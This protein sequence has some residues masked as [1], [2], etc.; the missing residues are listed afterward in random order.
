MAYIW[1]RVTDRFHVA[2][3]TAQSPD[4]VLFYCLVRSVYSVRIIIRS[5]H[6]KRYRLFHLRMFFFSS[7]AIQLYPLNRFTYTCAKSFI[8]M[9]HGYYLYNIFLLL[10]C[11]RATSITKVF[12]SEVKRNSVLFPR[13]CAL[14]HCPCSFCHIHPKSYIQHVNSIHCNAVLACK[15][16]K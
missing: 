13:I 12:Y 14:F 4:T 11:R 16:K 3:F 10:M 5:T 2:G 7:D 1:W 15:E 9:Q 8:L 6:S